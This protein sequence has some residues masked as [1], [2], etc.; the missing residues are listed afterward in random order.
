[1]GG[2]ARSHPDD[3]FARPETG[4]F[5][6]M[7]KPTILFISPGPTM[8]AHSDVYQSQYKGLSDKYR[9]FILTTS[10]QPEVFSIGDFTYTSMKYSASPVRV[11]RFAFFCLRKALGLVFRRQKVDLVCTYDPLLTGLIGRLVSRLLRARFAPEV[12]GVYTSPF[13]WVDAPDDLRTKLKRRLYPL[14][15]RVVLRR[16]DGIKLLY[17][18]QLGPLA[19]LAAGKVVRAF[20][21]FVPTNQ[22]REIR[23]DREV[24]FAGFPFRRKGVD[25]LIAAFKQVAP[26]FPDWKLKILGWFPDSR[27]LNEAIAGHPQIYHHPPVHHRDMAEHIGSCAILGPPSRSEAMGRVLVEAMAAAKP[28]IGSKVDGIPNVIA[29]GVDGLLCEPGNAQDLAAKLDMLMGNPAL[30]QNLGKAGQ[31]RL[32]AEFSQE[33]YFTNA[34]EFYGD[35]LSH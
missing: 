22:F 24:L 17:P 26:R 5:A 6:S 23:E 4:W 28:R 31:R 29:D 18:G 25:V 1:M 19:D 15:M 13:E 35:V 7:M 30:R 32:K 27:E 16:S 12:N 3:Q 8:G 20:P 33:T 21:C 11:L 2:C 34:G 9:G 14:V 10:Y